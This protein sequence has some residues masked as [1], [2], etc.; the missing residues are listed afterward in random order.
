MRAQ[1]Y[2]YYNLYF[3]V[4][5]FC[6][7]YNLSLDWGYDGYIPVISSC[8]YIQYSHF[9]SVGNIFIWLMGAYIQ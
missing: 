9:L 7:N 3:Y 5:L 8:V 1:L 2:E 4:I 6:I